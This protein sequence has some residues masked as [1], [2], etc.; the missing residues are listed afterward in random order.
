MAGTRTLTKIV[1]V[2]AAILLFYGANPWVE[3]TD[4]IVRTVVT[5]GF[6]VAV[7]ALLVLL[8]QERKQP[9]GAPDD[10]TVEIQG[11][12]FARFLFNNPR[13]GLF[14]LPIRLFLGFAWLEAGL[15]KLA[16]DGWINNGGTAL[17]GFWKGAV[18]IPASGSG[19][20][21]YDWY[22]DFISTL[23]NGGHEQWFAW[24]ITFGEIA[25][26]VGLLVGMLTGIAAFFGALMNM[27]FLLAGSASS[28]PVLF[29]LAI[30]LMLG[31]KVAG[32]YGIDRHLLRLVGTPWRPG[33]IV[34]GNTHPVGAPAG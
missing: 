12:A 4:G 16:G 30:G 13:A 2:A 28:N 14:W 26:G 10:E 25:I 3:P 15:H 6:W 24:V 20:I 9:V 22:R 19:K 33:P 7:V 32:Y 23:L 21:T 27:S 8:C 5:Y 31:W 18:A 29:T 1:G 34:G 11:P 17:A